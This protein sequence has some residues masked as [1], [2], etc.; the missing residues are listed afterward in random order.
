MARTAIASLAAACVMLCGSALGQAQPPEPVGSAG[1]AASPIGQAT[2]GIDPI[3]LGATVA[4]PGSFQM[5][6]VTQKVDI[7]DA[8]MLELG[9]LR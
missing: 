6:P 8:M 2:A 9:P 1:E 4:N 3:L 7:S 5:Q